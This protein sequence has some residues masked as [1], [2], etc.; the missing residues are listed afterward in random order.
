LNERSTGIYDLLVKTEKRKRRKARVELLQAVG[1][2]EEYFEEGN[3][4]IDKVT[5]RGIECKLCIEACPTNALY[6]DDGVV[7]IEEDLCIYC[8]ACVLSCIVDDCIIVTRKRKSG[9]VEKL[10]TPREAILLMHRQ[11]VQQRGETIK[12]II[13]ELAKT[14]NDKESKADNQ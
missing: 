7:K 13:A 6:W 11:S 4:T 2:S 14:K 5:C 10:G 12:S 9:E 1:V 3:I 8:N